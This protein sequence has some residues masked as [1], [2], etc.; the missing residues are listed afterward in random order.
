MEIIFFDAS[1]KNRLEVGAFSK[2][3]FDF[4]SVS[5]FFIPKNIKNLHNVFMQN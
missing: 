4:R 3:T 5:S 2:S 1:I